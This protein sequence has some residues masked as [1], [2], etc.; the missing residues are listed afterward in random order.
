MVPFYLVDNHKS[1]PRELKVHDLFCTACINYE[2]S[3]VI[4][5][6]N[7]KGQCYPHE[8]EV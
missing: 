5:R 6:E 3:I 2:H 1:G 4:Y 8:R 7:V